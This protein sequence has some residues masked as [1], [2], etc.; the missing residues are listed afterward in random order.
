MYLAAS[1]STPRYRWNKSSL[2]VDYVPV[3]LQTRITEIIR[4]AGKS[5]HP[6]D[7]PIRTPSTRD[8]EGFTNLF[9]YVTTCKL[10]QCT[11]RTLRHSRHDAR[12]RCPPQASLSTLRVPDLQATPRFLTMDLEQFREFKA[13][14]DD[15]PGAAPTT[16]RLLLHHCMLECSTRQSLICLLYTSPSPRDS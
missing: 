3:T 15:I 8:R 13:K 10:V 5:H 16:V 7:L 6:I 11:I 14:N 4:L 2:K 9:L 1:N 12:P